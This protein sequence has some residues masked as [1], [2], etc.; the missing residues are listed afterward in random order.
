MFVF[1]KFQMILTKSNSLITKEI[2]DLA[3]YGGSKV[4]VELLINRENKRSS[5]VVNSDE[6]YCWIE[7]MEWISSNNFAQKA[8]RDFLYQNTTSLYYELGKY[9]IG[10]LTN[11]G[12]FIFK[13][14]I[15][16]FEK[17]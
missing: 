7:W 8:I 15:T 11:D 3:C 5:D 14:T 10:F 13:L 17:S 2:F 1:L 4:I 9:F 6:N 12:M 16:T